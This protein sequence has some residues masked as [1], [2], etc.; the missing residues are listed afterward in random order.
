MLCKT[1]GRFTLVV[2]SID[3]RAAGI[4]RKGIARLS[5]IAAYTPMSEV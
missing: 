3:G 2:H 4:F 5:A 1:L